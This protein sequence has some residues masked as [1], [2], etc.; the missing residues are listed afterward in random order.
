MIDYAREMAMKKSCMYSEYGLSI[1]F[2]CS[3]IRKKML[4]KPEHRCIM[5]WNIVIWLISPQWLLWMCTYGCMHVTEVCA[6][7]WCVGTSQELERER[8]SIIF[9]YV[10]K[11]VCDCVRIWNWNTCNLLSVDLFIFCVSLLKTGEKCL[12]H[13][14]ILKIVISLP[15]SRGEMMYACVHFG[16]GKCVCDYE[17]GRENGVWWHI[18]HSSFTGTHLLSE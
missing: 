9:M 13:V 17:W 14:C 1:C 18:V 12:L 6:H 4:N 7:L 2:S 15:Y 3:L 10:W 5:N 8:E 16:E 11:Y